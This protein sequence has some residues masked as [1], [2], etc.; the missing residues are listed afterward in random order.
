MQM[1][2][3]L[4][5]NSVCGPDCAAIFAA[6]GK[7]MP[8]ASNSEVVC[9]AAPAKPVPVGRAPALCSGPHKAPLQE[10]EECAIS[11]PALPLEVIVSN[12]DQLRVSAVIG[13]HE[14]HR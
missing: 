6:N 11:A 1:S 12:A 7:A 14:D 3:P 8:H 13:Q 5:K 10:I 2:A 4:R 9:S